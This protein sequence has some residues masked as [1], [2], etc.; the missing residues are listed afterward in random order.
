MQCCEATEMQQN[1]A[2][3][4]S[5]V[6]L[7]K[8]ITGK[9]QK[10]IYQKL[11]KCNS[12]KRQKSSVLKLLKFYHIKMQKCSNPKVPEMQYCSC[13]TAVLHSCIDE[14][15]QRRQLHRY[16]DAELRES[17]NVD[18]YST[19]LLQKCR[20]V[21]NTCTLTKEKINTLAASETSVS[22]QGKIRL[23]SFP[24]THRHCE[25]TQYSIQRHISDNDLP[26]L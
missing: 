18:I 25:F 20:V 21:C 16:R 9:L 8:C 13:V 10:C 6:K 17:R 22:L 1:K 15:V 23:D 4:C 19:R 7:Q 24:A 2:A 14:E 12:V 11:P 3:K 26:H 5:V